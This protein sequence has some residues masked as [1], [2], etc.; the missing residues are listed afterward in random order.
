LYCPS[1]YEKLV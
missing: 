1:T